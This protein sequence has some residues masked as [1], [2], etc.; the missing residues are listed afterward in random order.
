MAAHQRQRAVI[1]V[2][3]GTSLDGIDAVL[4]AVEGEGLDLSARCVRHVTHELGPIA[5]DLRR[6]AAGEPMTASRLARLALDLGERCAEAI[7]DAAAIAEKLDL[8]AVHGQTVFHRPPV[9]WQLLNPSTIAARFGCPVLA[10]V[11]QADLAAGGSGAPV[12]PLADWVLFRDPATRRAV[13]NLGGF[14]NVT[15]P[16]PTLDD[17]RGFDVCVC[18]LVLDEV[19]RRTLDA[20]WDDGGAAAARGRIDTVATDALRDIL[21]R[22]R[23]AG[24]SLGTGDEATQWVADF[25]PSVAGPDLAASAVDA[26]AACLAA[27][28]D[29]HDIAEVIVAGGGT[30][31]AAL[32]EALASHAGVPARVSDELGVP[33]QAREGLAMAVLGALAADDVPITLPQVTGRREQPLPMTWV[34]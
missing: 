31:N 25:A 10:D 26:V 11:R 13:V 28:L 19:A 21:D 4:A 18:N 22:Q 1:G 5:D 3:T 8:I 7:A 20:P 9:S 14:C 32:V 15:V 23:G 17:V 30:R 27:A 34:L 12:T 29:D 33:A 6:V 2:M 16:G 24:R